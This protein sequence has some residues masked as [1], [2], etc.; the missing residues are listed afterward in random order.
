MPIL[1]REPDI[2]PA[3]LFAR[4][5][6]GGPD[7]VSA[8][9]GEEAMWWAVYTRSRQ[10][11]ELMR[12]LQA[13][14]IPFYSPLVAHRSRS[15]QGR[16]RTSYIPLFSNY[17]FLLGDL[18]ARTRALTTNTISRTIE[19]DDSRHLVRD[20]RQIFD[21]IARG[22]PVTPEAKLQPGTPVR[23]KSGAM[24]GIEGT[25]IQRHG[26][27]HLI[28]TVNFLQQGASVKLQDFEV[29]SLT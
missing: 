14:E 13:M 29:Q 12:K 19:V 24:K 21:L 6:D 2:F 22:A 7:A 8:G 20:L 11:K 26:E 25:V 18:A 15:P 28:V 9:F 3:D 16:I 1:D 23:I 10:E 5:G 4:L 17:V 27:T